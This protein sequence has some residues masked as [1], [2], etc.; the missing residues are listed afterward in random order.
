MGN[1]YRRSYFVEQCGI[2]VGIDLE[3][4]RTDIGGHLSEILV[5]R[6][7]VAAE[8]H[9]LEIVGPNPHPETVEPYFFI[10]SGGDGNGLCAASGIAPTRLIHEIGGESPAQEDVL[11]SFASVGSGLPRF[12]ELSH[13][14]GEYERIFP[15]IDRFL[16]EHIGV[17][18]VISAPQRI[19]QHRAADGEAA[20][21]FDTQDTVVSHFASR[22]QSRHNHTAKNLS[23][24]TGLYFC[25]FDSCKA[26]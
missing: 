21:L 5:Q 10:E 14:V 8:L 18:A 13:A 25:I 4:D 16:I 1:E 20:L 26:S 12:G 11:K 17:V 9:A 24:H 22:Q 19:G 3:I 15:R 23:V 2:G 6:L 7:P